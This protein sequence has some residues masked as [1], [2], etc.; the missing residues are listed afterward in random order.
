MMLRSK[1]QKSI[2]AFLVIILIGS[3][4]TIFLARK[5]SGETGSGANQAYSDAPK[6]DRDEAKPE[7][8]SEPPNIKYDDKLPE[9]TLSP[10]AVATKPDPYFRKQIMLRGLVVEASANR[11][12]I[13]SQKQPDEPYSIELDFSK[14]GI[15]PNIYKNSG[16]E[17]RDKL[18]L[19]GP[20]TV[21]GILKALED[22]KPLTFIVEKVEN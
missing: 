17:N 4:L 20:V 7:G 16:Y 15:D 22:G 11:Y 9:G 6:P 10:H 13:V 19:S 2:I 14:S 3:G 12:T 18:Q 5:P 8:L 21:T 1:K